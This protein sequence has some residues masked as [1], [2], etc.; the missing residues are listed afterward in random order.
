LIRNGLERSGKEKRREV[1]GLDLRGTGREMKR[2]VRDKMS[3]E[4][5]KAR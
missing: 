5:I 3:K 2:L 1:M 4:G